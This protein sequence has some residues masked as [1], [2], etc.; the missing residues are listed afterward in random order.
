[1]V[2]IIN[3]TVPEYEYKHTLVVIKKIKNTPKDYPRRNN[4]IQK[5]PL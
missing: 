5:K 1:M 3:I 2:N 4:L